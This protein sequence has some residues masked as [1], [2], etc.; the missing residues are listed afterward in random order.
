M[1]LRRFDLNR[2][3]HIVYM[4]VRGVV[5]LA[6]FPIDMRTTPMIGSGRLDSA[7]L[8]KASR[9]SSSATSRAS[10]RCTYQSAV[11]CHLIRPLE[12]VHPKTVD[13]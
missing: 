2:S 4:G 7:M 9:S 5:I 12:V 6:R 10:A 1:T 11:D 3:V 8:I 13:E